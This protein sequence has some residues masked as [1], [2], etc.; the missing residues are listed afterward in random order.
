M[1]DYYSILGIP[2]YASEQTIKDAYRRLAKRWHPDANN[3]DEHA[4]RMMQDLNRAKEVLFEADTR[5]EYRRV[6]E[7]QDALSADNIKRLKKTFRD[8]RFETPSEMPEMRPFPRA[9]F[10]LLM[11]LLAITITIAIVKLSEMSNA[12]QN[13][14]DP[15][16]SLIRR[17]QKTELFPVAEVDTIRVPD[18]PIERL[19]QMATVLAMMNEYKGAEKYWAKCLAMDSTNIEITTSLMLAYLRQGEIAKAVETVRDHVRVDT[20]LVVMYSLLGEYFTKDHKPMDASN[21]FEK[22]VE[23]GAKVQSPSERIREY[24]LRAKKIIAKG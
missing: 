18:V 22:V 21:A 7:L 5:Q 9:K 14:F 11:A 1:K 2:R 24:I 3:G 13:K 8:R 17:N 12:P 4:Q 20:N 10:I 6:L 15:V 16:E 23:V 19:S